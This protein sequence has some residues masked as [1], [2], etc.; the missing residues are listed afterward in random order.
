ML[1]HLCQGAQNSSQGFQEKRAD[2]RTLFDFLQT[3][4]VYYSP[5][6]ESPTEVTLADIQPMAAAPPFTDLLHGL[7]AASM[8]F[9]GLTEPTRHVVDACRQELQQ[10][11]GRIQQLQRDLD[12]AAAPLHDIAAKIAASEFPISRLIELVIQQAL[13]TQSRLRR[14]TTAPFRLVNQT[15]TS[16]REAA[17]RTGRALVDVFRVTPTTRAAVRPWLELEQERLHEGL[18]AEHGLFHLWRQQALL[19]NAASQAWFT[20]ERLEHLRHT[21]QQTP[22]PAPAQEW[23]GYVRQEITL[24]SQE[25][26]WLCTLLP[27]LGDIVAMLGGAVLV[28]DLCTTGGLFGTAVVLGSL[29]TAGGGAALGIV[30]DWLTHWHLD[31]VVLQA[32]Q[33]WRQQRT[34]ELR[35][36]LEQHV[37]QPLFQPWIAQLHALQQAPVAQCQQACDD[38]DALLQ[39]LRRP[40]YVCKRC[41]AH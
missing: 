12:N 41:I 18:V 3:C 21:V 40:L 30:M 10:V 8:L 32:Q 9:A 39:D 37:W 15:L 7:D 2:G 4:P 1:A 23:E 11:H 34:A 19:G 27:G 33:R 29:G 22:V 16:V 26:P 20:Q 17:M 14:A 24:W 36:H 31:Q 35:Q 25:H 6:R 13:S 38:L 5:R 28:I